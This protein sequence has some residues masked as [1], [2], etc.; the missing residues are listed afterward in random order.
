MVGEYSERAALPIDEAL[1]T[2]ARDERLRAALDYCDWYGETDKDKLVLILRLGLFGKKRH[3]LKQAGKAL[4]FGTARAGQRATRAW[5]SLLSRKNAVTLE[6]LYGMQ[7]KRPGR[8]GWHCN[9]EDGELFWS[10]V[11]EAMG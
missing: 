9:R 2:C 8:L 3:T 7:P 6:E 4:G 11:D 10:I 5:L 1:T